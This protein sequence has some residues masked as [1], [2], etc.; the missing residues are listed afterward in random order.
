MESDE[1]TI[2]NTEEARDQ[3][4]HAVLKAMDMENR[5]DELKQAI[6]ALLAMR[7]K[8]GGESTEVMVSREEEG[9]IIELEGVSAARESTTLGDFS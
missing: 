1:R 3:L 9:E 7:K 2:E 6:S 8:E 4:D 5:L